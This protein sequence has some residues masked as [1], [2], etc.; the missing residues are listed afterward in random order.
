MLSNFK[1]V[2]K[3]IGLFLFLALAGI[4]INTGTSYH[5]RKREYTGRTVHFR[6]AL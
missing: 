6:K 5:Y 2:K 3:R 4:A 1:M